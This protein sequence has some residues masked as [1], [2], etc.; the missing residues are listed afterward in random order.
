MEY[1]YQSKAQPFPLGHVTLTEGIFHDS[2]KVGK[3]YLLKF[4]I[5]RLLSPCYDAQ[6]KTPE[7]PRYGGWEANGVSGQT[8]GHW[9]SAVAHMIAEEKDYNL[10]IKL[11]Y[12]IYKLSE[13]QD[14]DGYVGGFNKTPLENVFNNPNNFQVDGFGLGGHWVPWYSLHKIFAG[15]ID[16]YLFAE[17]KEAL[18]IAI[19]FADWAAYGVSHL[20]DAQMERMLSC[21]HGGMCEVFADLYAITHNEIY[22]ITAEKFAHKE[23]LQPLSEE[24]DELCGRH[25]N[26][27]IPKIIGAEK[28]HRLTEDEFGYGRAA[29]FFWNTVT[30]KRSYAIGG[31]SVHEHFG[32]MED[33]ILDTQTCETC[34]TYN[35]LKLS[36]HLYCDTL[37]KRYMD[38]YEKALYNH[39]L[40]SQDPESGEKT[41][42][43]SMKP[44]HFK[45]YSDW[46]NS[47][48][49]CVGSGLE[50]PTRY[51]EH[52]YHEN[53]ENLY[54]NLFISSKLNW[55]DKGINLHQETSFPF[56]ETVKLKIEKGSSEFTMNIR[57]PEWA[58][59]PIKVWVNGALTEISEKDGYLVL[60]RCWSIGD[61]IKIRFPMEVMTYHAKDDNNKIAFQYG[62]IMLAAALGRENFPETDCVSEQTRYDF[63]QSPEVDDL[64]VPSGELFNHI[65]PVDKRKLTFEIRDIAQPSGK[66]FT[67]MPFFMIHHQRY[68]VYFHMY[69]DKEYTHEIL[70]EKIRRFA[71]VDATLD[72]VL[73]NE[74][75]S[76]ISHNARSEDSNSGYSKEM[77]MGWRD[78]KD[79]GWFAYSMQVNPE[80]SNWLRANYWGNDGN[81]LEEGVK[82]ERAFEVY[83]D[84][85]L[86][87]MQYLN[88]NKQDSK[89]IVAY[90]IPQELTINKNKIEVMFRP[91]TGSSNEHYMAGGLYELRTMK[92]LIE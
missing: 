5:D 57:K 63:C 33:E 7:K 14:S 88:K 82:Y 40:A 61:V 81:H 28:L 74:Q 90:E 49:C 59:G 27:Q 16:A 60:F 79:N 41:Y 77:G 70:E 36:G 53:Q 50:N 67:L 17:S 66:T 12:C 4:D 69:T 38:Y 15:L 6:G 46:E 52:I 92:N 55:E 44:G 45:V 58:E 48:W 31:N 1:L 83:V 73:P 54:V 23:I 76:E 20:N 19:R 85:T 72:I 29:R 84:G 10:I 8:L 25:A 86:I 68:T 18:N 37:D 13:L 3:Q 56:E 35:M 32:H 26:T 42:F 22:L 62:P 24:R 43:V 11:N 91:K 65:Y 89:E 9:I 87:G 47:F 71:F 75:Q 30:N 64:V 2:Y 80:I 39:I 51:V 34:N 21:E 78:A